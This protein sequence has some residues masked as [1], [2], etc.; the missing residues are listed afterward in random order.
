MIE[1]SDLRMMRIALNHGAGQMPVLGFG[2]LIPDAALTISATR[3]ALARSRISTLRLRGTIPERARGRRG[4]AGRPCRS[5]DRARGHFCYYKV[6][7]LQSP[8]RARRPAFEASLDRLG[9]KYL[10][11]SSCGTEAS[12]ANLAP[13]AGATDDDCRHELVH[14]HHRRSE[15]LCYEVIQVTLLL[16]VAAVPERGWGLTQT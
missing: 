9:L 12:G 5:R 14:R 7:E 1:S 11:R 6:V 16:R 13:T 8:T 2:T 4:V 3:D 10:K 15:P